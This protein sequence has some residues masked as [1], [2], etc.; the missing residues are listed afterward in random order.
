MPPIKGFTSTGF[1]LNELTAI[2]CEIRY[3]GIKKTKLKKTNFL[4]ITIYYFKTIF[5]R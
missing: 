3:A 2:A 5:K 1:A 4:N